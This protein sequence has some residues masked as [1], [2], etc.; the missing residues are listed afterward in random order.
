MIDPECM[1]YNTNAGWNIT[2]HQTSERIENLAF[3]KNFHE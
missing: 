2:I 3:E 1:I